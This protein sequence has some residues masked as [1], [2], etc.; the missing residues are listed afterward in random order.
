MLDTDR[1]GRGLSN[2]R[3]GSEIGDIRGDSTPFLADSIA[4]FSFIS[5][6]MALLKDNDAI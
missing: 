4:K 1:G 5:R 3:L 6:Q 2:G